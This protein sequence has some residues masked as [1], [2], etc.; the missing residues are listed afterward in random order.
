M[1]LTRTTKPPYSLGTPAPTD[2]EREFVYMLAHGLTDTGKTT[3]A[4]KAPGPLCYIHCSAKR[5]GLIQTANIQHISTHG[6]PIQT[7]DFSFPK[8]PTRRSEYS[9]LQDI[10]DVAGT[11]WQGFSDVFAEAFTYART[12]IIDT[13][14]NLYQLDRFAH[15]G[16]LSPNFSYERGKSGNA[17]RRALWGPVNSQW[18][19]HMRQAVK[20]QARQKTNVILLTHSRDEYKTVKER[21]GNRVTFNETKTGNYLPD[22]QARI[23]GW[24]DVVVETRMEQRVSGGD[25]YYAIIRKPWWNGAIGRGTE[26][27]ITDSS[28]SFEDVMFEIT[29]DLERWCE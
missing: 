1:K 6:Y 22:C 5:E 20:S 4:F 19:I 8:P 14:F 29:D 18:Y 23:T 11:K 16:A 17:D 21:K 25:K 26:L 7:Y 13:V 28:T 12:I 2:L 27:D 24:V 10:E 15:F 9:L 3:L